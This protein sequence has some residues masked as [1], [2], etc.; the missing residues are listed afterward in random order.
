MSID[1][2]CK[3]DGEHPDTNGVERRHILII[4]TALGEKQE[5]RSYAKSLQ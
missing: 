5:R 2:V 4:S 3:T 1:H